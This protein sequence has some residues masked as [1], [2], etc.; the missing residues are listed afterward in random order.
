MNRNSPVDLPEGYVEF[1]KNLETWQNEQQIRLQQKCSYERVDEVLPLLSEQKKPIMILGQFV[2]D[3]VQYRAVFVSLLAFMSEARPDL[4][5]AMDNLIKDIEQLDFQ[6]LV[7]NLLN[8]K[9]EP[10]AALAETYGISSE[11]LVFLFEHAVRPFL[12]IY[13]APYQEQLYEDTFQHWD[14]PSQCPVCGSK[15]H[16]SRLRPIDSRRF[17]FCDRCFIEWE[18]KYLQCIHCGN[19]TP[20][21]IKYLSIENDESHQL[22]TCEKCK[23][24]LKTYNEKQGGRGVDLF[25]AN[26][27]TIYLDLLAQEKGYTNHDV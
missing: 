1:Y 27:E 4:K 23:G 10:F 18:A 25:I 3:P 26:I 14:F 6:Q 15:S 17:M 22:Y 24:Y 2:V 11:L 5:E 13:A 19:D 8:G 20:G 12:R 21:T 9:Y 7:K 16:F